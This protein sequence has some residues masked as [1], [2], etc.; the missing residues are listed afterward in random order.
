MAKQEVNIVK[1]KQKIYEKIIKVALLI[2][3]S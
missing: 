2:D 1:E 3:N